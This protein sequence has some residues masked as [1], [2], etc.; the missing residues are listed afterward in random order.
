MDPS[1]TLPGSSPWQVLN[2]LYYYLGLT[3]IDDD[4]VVDE[5]LG[6]PT[7]LLHAAIDVN[8]GP[9]VHWV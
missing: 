2:G 7:Y 3:F 4:R 8:R 1:P 9:A 6:V 5:L